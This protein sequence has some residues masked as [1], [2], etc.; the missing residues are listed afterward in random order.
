MIPPAIV[1]GV[2]ALFG[3]AAMALPA[4]LGISPVLGLPALAAAALLGWLG[5]QPARLTLAL[6]AMP[7]FTLTLLGFELPAATPLW[8]APEIEHVLAAEGLSG[9]RIVSAGFHEPSLPFLAG[10]TTQLAPAGADAGLALTN[11]TADVAAVAERDLRSLEDEL[12]LSGMTVRVLGRVHG[13][14]YSRGRQ[15]DVTLFQRSH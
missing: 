14:N 10:T 7:V 2:A 4:V 15:T 11:G 3:A 9:K 13:F 8:I 6:V 5:A 12:V 1:I